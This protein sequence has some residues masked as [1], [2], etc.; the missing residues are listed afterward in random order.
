MAVSKFFW[1]ASLIRLELDGG[2]KICDVLIEMRLV[3]ST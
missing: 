1:T 2:T 3:F